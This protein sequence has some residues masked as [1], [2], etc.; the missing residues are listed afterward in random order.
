[1]TNYIEDYLGRQQKL[2]SSLPVEKIRELITLFQ[3]AWEEDRQIFACG[4]G[5]SA[6]NA[7]HFITDLSK[8]A[9]DKL[10]KPFRGMSL[11]DN[12]AWMTALG[13]DY[14]FEDIFVRQ[15]RNFAGKGDLLMVL[16]VSGNSTNLVKAVKWAKEQGIFTI[17]LLGGNKGK[18]A[19]LADFK[20]VVESNHYGRVEDAHMSICHMLCYYFMEANT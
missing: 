14:A 7:A 15:L 6:A 1:M 13:N 16:S 9:S 4:N 20:I 11:N 2:L 10:S 8:G 5:G 3:K 17:A 12:I 19:E 18:L